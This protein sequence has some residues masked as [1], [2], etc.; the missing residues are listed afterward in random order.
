MKYIHH[1][2]SM[3]LFI[4]L[5]S[6]EKNLQVDPPD[7]EVR[8][9]K[10]T[11][12]V[13]DTIH[14]EF[15]GAPDN[16]TFYSGLPG[17]DYRFRERTQVEGGIPK[18]KVITQYGGGGN[19][20]ESLRLM[21]SN[22]LEELTAEG[23]AQAIWTDVTSQVDIAT[24]PTVVESDYL[25]LSPWVDTEKPFFIAFKFVGEKDPI[26]VP[27]NWIVRELQAVTEL[28]D[29]SEIPVADRVNAGW[30]I[31]D[32][33]NP[34]SVWTIRATDVVIIG[35]GRNADPSE[36]WLITK[37]LYFTKVPPDTG[38]PIQNIGSNLLSDY[39]YTYT[40]PGTYHVAFL[41][42][43]ASADD[44]KSVVRE[45]EITIVPE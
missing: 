9:S 7:F 21:V 23:I 37:P 41:A 22:D 44:Y 11:Y 13:G 4:G 6:C 34:A 32:V 40:T 14:F 45:F 30:S 29:G 36:D 15:S 39:S 35:G 1:I 43:N 20:L 12:K 24:N 25:D 10:T 27:G 33:L 2:L 8:L 3:V 38:T 18:A 28:P 16:I 26:T 17:A 42:S 5:I 19:Q 31:I